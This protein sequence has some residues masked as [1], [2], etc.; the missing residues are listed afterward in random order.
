[1]VRAVVS[2]NLP[3]RLRFLPRATARHRGSASRGRTWARYRRE[4][5]VRMLLRASVRRAPLVPSTLRAARL[6]GSGGASPLRE[7]A[8]CNRCPPNYPKPDDVGVL[9]IL[10]RR[11]VPVPWRHPDRSAAAPRSLVPVAARAH[12]RRSSTIGRPP[13][14]TLSL[15]SLIYNQPSYDRHGKSRASARNAAFFRW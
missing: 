8:R 3:S 9:S 10:G 13:P 7:V 1:M 11:W 4:A 12:P 2:S 15:S 5:A 14:S 6:P